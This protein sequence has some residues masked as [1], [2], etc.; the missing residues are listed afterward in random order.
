MSEWVSRTTYEP[1]PRKTSN[2][3]MYPCDRGIPEN[4]NNRGWHHF[5]ASPNGVI[6]CRYCGRKP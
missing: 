1:Q 4:V 5:E 3:Q 6:C 2:V